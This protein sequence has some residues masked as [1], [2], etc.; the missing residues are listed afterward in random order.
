MSEAGEHPTGTI[1]NLLEDLRSSGNAARRTI[2][3]RL[4]RLTRADLSAIARGE[5]KRLQ[6]PGWGATDLL[7]EAM[8]RL[9]TSGSYELP[10]NRTGFLA[11]MRVVMR[12]LRIDHFHLSHAEK[13]GGKQENVTL[14]ES[15]VAAGRR[16]PHTLRADID[17]RL[18]LLSGQQ[19]EIVRLRFFEG[20]TEAEV[21]VALGIS[22]DQVQR[23]WK[24]ARA[25]LADELEPWKNS[26]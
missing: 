22:E 20:L 8:L 24:A 9:H 2:L 13:R 21:A 4:F 14:D 18:P 11:V 5:A 3:N 15:V 10:A 23:R 1:T 25:I 7:Q 12:R 26:G 19:R 6:S 16:V 17:R